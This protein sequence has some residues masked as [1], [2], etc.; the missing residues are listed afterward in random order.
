MLAA[1]LQDR[2]V[3]LAGS[4]GR[5][6]VI[7]R[8][9]LEAAGALVFG[10]DAQEGHATDHSADL[11][12]E[13]AVAD[14]FAAATASYGR[15]DSLVHVVGTW[16]MA[17]LHETSLDHWNRIIDVNLTSVFLC[18]R[19]VTRQLVS[20]RNGGRLVA[21][22]ARP[23]IT[24]GTAQQGPYAVSKAGVARLVEA[25]TDEYG[26]RGITAAAIA[27]SMILFGD[28]QPGTGGA[29]AEDIARGCVYLAGEGGATHA[30]AVLPF[31]GNG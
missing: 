9:L 18:F 12:S 13:A 25:V 26:E 27:P 2:V 15:I 24:R 5:L 11:T 30:G 17:P 19:E 16:D 8:P 21:V 22:S 23:G 4:S 10:I 28:E 20:A 3:V 14:A 29:P 1:D 7:T 31:Y 6:G